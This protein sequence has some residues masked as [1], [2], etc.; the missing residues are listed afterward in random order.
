MDRNAYCGLCGECLRTARRTTLANLRLPGH[1]LLVVEGL[2]LD[3]AYKA[4]SCWPVPAST[5]VFLG[6]WDGPGL[7]QPSSPGPSFALA[8]S[9][10][11]WWRC[12]THLPLQRSPGGGGLRANC[13]AK[14]SL[15]WPTC[16]CRWGWLHDRSPLPVFAN[17]LCPSGPL[18][19]LAGGWTLGTRSFA[20]QPADRSGSPAKRRFCGWVGLAIWTAAAR[21]GAATERLR[22]GTRGPVGRPA[23]PSRLLSLAV[24]RL[25][26][27]PGRRIARTGVPPAARYRAVGALDQ[28]HAWWLVRCAPSIEAIRRRTV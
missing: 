24:R 26:M 15:P 6:P 17:S 14:V 1:D 25:L 10:A 28:R 22:W 2:C 7:V 16:W 8:F 20:W 3:E 5:L 18:I 21:C 23:G 13:P 12:R 11:I 19:P 4:S 9:A 27:P